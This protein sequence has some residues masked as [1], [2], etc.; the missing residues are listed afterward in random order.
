MR[1]IN[2]RH[3]KHA[4]PPTSLHGQLLWREFYYTCAHGTPK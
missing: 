2:A 4:K 1:Q 3:P